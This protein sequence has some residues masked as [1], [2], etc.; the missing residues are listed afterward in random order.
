MKK[1]MLFALGLCYALN[2]NN[3]NAQA[4]SMDMDE[5]AN[6]AINYRDTILIRPDATTQVLFL[7]KNLDEMINYTGLDS[8][9]NLLV[10]DV[11]KAR[12]QP[13][14]P[15]Q[16]KLTHYFVHPN[17][18]RRLKAESEDYAEPQVNVADEERSLYLDLLPYQFIIY[19]FAK[20]YRIHIYLK[21]PDDLNKLASV[22]FKDALI[23]ASLN[24]KTVKHSY[25]I[26]ALKSNDNWKV[27]NSYGNKLDQLESGF[28]IGVNLIGSRLSPLA[29]FDLSLIF[30]NKYNHPFIKTGF[31]YSVSSFSNWDNSEITDLCIL[32]SYD[33]KFL[34]NLSQDKTHWFGVQFGIMDNYKSSSPFDNKFK[35]GFVSEGFGRLNYSLDVILFEK[36]QSIYGL[37]VKLPF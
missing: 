16:S 1:Q 11:D 35:F 20:N 18:K 30:N 4:L 29:N 17:G 14:Y 36:K 12:T 24:K 31:S 15:A 8:L 37:T 6:V 5:S 26:D 3:S 21:N 27:E 9:K 2:I 7:G 22:N 34:T 32:S 13:G 10:A 19:D 33:L 25:R 28:A 23:A